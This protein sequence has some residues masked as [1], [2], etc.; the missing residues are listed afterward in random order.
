MPVE[1]TKA[2]YID[3]FNCYDLPFSLG[4]ITTDSMGVTCADTNLASAVAASTKLKTIDYVE[5]TLDDEL[6]TE[7][8]SLL[9]T[10]RSV[11]LSVAK[12]D[13]GQLG[14]IGG[15]S[16]DPAQ[17]RARIRHEIQGIVPVYKIW[18]VEAKRM[19]YSADQEP[20][21]IRVIR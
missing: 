21:T 4:W 1:L 18:E 15:V 2:N 11:R 3:L 13:A 7:L 19:G 9:T 6:R 17:K 12:Q 16:Y 20:T 10:Y 5:N 14:G 8:V